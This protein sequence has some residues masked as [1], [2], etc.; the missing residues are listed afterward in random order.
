MRGYMYSTSLRVWDVVVTFADGRTTQ[1]R[2]RARTFDVA[3]HHAKQA[4]GLDAFIA[5]ATEV[6]P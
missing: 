4:A 6:K 2:L 3:Q 5:R 1:M